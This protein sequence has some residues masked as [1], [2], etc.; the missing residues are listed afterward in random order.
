MR[1][2]VGV[3]IFIKWFG[4]LGGCYAGVFLV[5]YAIYLFSYVGVEV[6]PSRL[7]FAPGGQCGVER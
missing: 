7:R 4:V 1:P 6:T 2:V 5:F 3:V